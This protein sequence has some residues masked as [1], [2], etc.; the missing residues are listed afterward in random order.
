MKIRNLILSAFFLLIITGNVEAASFDC[1]KATSEVE[2]LICGDEELSKL[3]ESLNKA[4]LQALKRFDS[5]EQMIKSQ[6]Q[7]LK[8]DRNACKN[9]ECIRK[10]YET[11]IKELG[12][13]SNGTAIL[14]LPDG[15]TSPSKGQANVS[16]SPVIERPQKAIETAIERQEVTAAAEPVSGTYSRTDV[17]RDWSAAKETYGRAESKMTL[18]MKDKNSFEFDLSIVGGNFHT[19]TLSGIAVRRGPFFEYKGLEPIFASP[20]DCVLK[21]WFQRNTVRLEHDPGK[22]RAPCGER[23]IFRGAVLYR[24]G[25]IGKANLTIDTNARKNR[26]GGSP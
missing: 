14:T 22:C 5:K 3:D 21:F 10:A 8:N 17:I 23:A 26:S 18:T 20:D 11:R 4:Y 12:S 19:C 16:R 24:S 1:G 9:A 15:R 6:R 7:W 13:S 2:K 25:A